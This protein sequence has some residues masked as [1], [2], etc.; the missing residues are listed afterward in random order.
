VTGLAIGRNRIAD[1]NREP[2][3]TE[4]LRC[5]LGGA[6]RV[7]GVLG[8][9]ADGRNA[10]PIDPPR[11]GGFLVGLEKVEHLVQILGGH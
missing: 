7:R 6:A 10:E 9:C 2:G 4:L 11:N 1:L 3:V 5:P 8:V